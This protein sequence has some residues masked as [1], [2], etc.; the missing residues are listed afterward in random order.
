VLQSADEN[1]IAK[2]AL[3][4]QF[5]SPQQ[6]QAVLRGACT[7]LEMDGFLVSIDRHQPATAAASAAAQTTSAVVRPKRFKPP[8]RIA[9]PL[10]Q[11]QQELPQAA[12]PYQRQQFSQ[13]EAGG[14]VPPARA[15][16][17]GRYSVT[18]N[19]L[20]DIWG[21]D[22]EATG[23]SY[24]E[25]GLDAAPPLPL[26]LA[27]RTF[28]MAATV[29]FDDRNERNETPKL[30][31]QPHKPPMQQQAH[32]PRPQQLQEPQAHTKAAV[33]TTATTDNL[34]DGYF[35][36]TTVE[37]DDG[38]EEQAIDHLFA[39]IPSRPLSS[40]PA[41]APLLVPPAPSPAA[42]AAP[43]RLVPDRPATTTKKPEI[44]P[45]QQRT[46]EDL[47]SLFG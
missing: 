21:T 32:Q 27:A 34:W 1:R 22:N 17:R 16:V 3:E 25:E 28:A 46:T 29:S 6:I 19:E 38:D 35:A 30:S 7:E 20:D 41:P 5:L 2:E 14:V 42:A 39:T 33:T 10:Q 4:V 47:L 9:P 24:P 18:E 23:S 36:P 13:V 26:A 15:M 8:Q 45:P 43:Q 12:D 31:Q 37:D 11:Q 40:K 44:A